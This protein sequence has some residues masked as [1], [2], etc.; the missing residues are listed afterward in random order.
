RSCNPA[1]EAMFGYAAADVVGTH[2]TRLL[3]SYVRDM[4]AAG[5]QHSRTTGVR[6]VIGGRAKIEGQRR[7]GSMFPVEL[8]LR[9]IP[10][11]KQYTCMAILR[12]LSARQAIE[13][14][15]QSL[16]EQLTS[17]SNQLQSMMT[18]QETS[19]H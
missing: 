19:T 11:G 13:E 8:T 15:L 16:I 2:V 5:L 12:D 4:P 9:D 10:K 7:D 1:A 14:Q 18:A 17:A 6:K 3:P